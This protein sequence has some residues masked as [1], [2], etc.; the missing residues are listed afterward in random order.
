MTM[1][2]DERLTA[3]VRE[4]TIHAAKYAQLSDSDA[5]VLVTDVLAAATAAV[6]AEGANGAVVLRFERTP[7]RFDV[8]IEWD[9]RPPSAPSASSASATTVH[10]S[11]EGRHQRC[12]V[13]HRAA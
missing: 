9:G 11:H 12:L 3:A 1:P 13:S 7:E 2:G 8:A 10:W 6:S 4:L 5:Q